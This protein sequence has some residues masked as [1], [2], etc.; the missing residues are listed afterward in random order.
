[1]K[2]DPYAIQSEADAYGRF[3]IVLLV[4]VVMT[5]VFDR[6]LITDNPPDKAHP[7]NPFTWKVMLCLVAVMGFLFLLL[8]YG[9]G[10]FAR[11]GSARAQK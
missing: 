4:F 8:K 3:V 2:P 5:F 1:M 7:T 11:Q 9:L 6:A 10:W